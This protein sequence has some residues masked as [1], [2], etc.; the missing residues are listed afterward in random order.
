M[1]LL[2][3]SCITKESHRSSNTVLHGGTNRR[4]AVCI[5]AS[6]QRRQGSSRVSDD[7]CPYAPLPMT[8][9]WGRV[10]RQTPK[11]PLR[12]RSGWADGA[13]MKTP[14]LTTTE[15]VTV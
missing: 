1:V 14:T 9:G 15:K 5:L 7:P 11:H 12:R 10:C 6:P 2:L 8:A 4:Q 3:G 13:P